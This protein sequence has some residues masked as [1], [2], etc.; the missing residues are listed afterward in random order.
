MMRKM[1]WEHN[2]LAA[3]VLLFVLAFGGCS[4]ISEGWVSS[5]QF[6]PAHDEEEMV[7]ISEI[8]GFPIYGTE[9]VHI[10]DKWFITFRRKTED[11][12]W[13]SRT[14]EVNKSIHDSCEVGD[15]VEF[16]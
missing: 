10:P 2:A 13:K 12:K 11:D 4:R 6:V 16:K 8:D 9:T 5:R 1:K 7:V 15:W 14:V 3:F